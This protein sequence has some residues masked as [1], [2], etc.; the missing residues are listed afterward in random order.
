MQNMKADFADFSLSL[1]FLIHTE[2]YVQFLCNTSTVSEGN[3]AAPLTI[4]LQLTPAGATLLFNI[5]IALT[6]SSGNAT[7]TVYG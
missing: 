5:T 4:Q 6:V 1:Y 2:I 3:S 7:G